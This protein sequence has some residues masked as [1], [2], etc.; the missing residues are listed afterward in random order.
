MNNEVQEYFKHQFLY[1]KLDESNNQLSFICCNSKAINFA[2]FQLATGYPF[3]S[4]RSS[5]QR[6]YRNIE[7]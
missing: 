4:S 1:H 6:I 3:N 2:D 5:A 7:V